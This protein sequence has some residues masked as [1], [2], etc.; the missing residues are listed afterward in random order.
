MQTLKIEVEGIEYTVAGSDFYSM[1][2]QVKAIS[3]RRWD[4][5][6]KLWKLPGALEEIR[7]KLGDLQ[8]L[9]TE[10]EILDAELA[11]IKKFQKWILED[12]EKI[13]REIEDLEADRGGYTRRWRNKASKK[14]GAW[15]L[16]CAIKAAAQD[17]ETMT[18][19]EINGLKR[20]CEIMG[21]L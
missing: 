18:Q 4:G 3:G 17:P 6:R 15:C 12:V 16:R 8:I 14:A 11:E 1:L 5:D 13:N 9:G 7:A 2:E 10:D 20:A 21:W 19:P